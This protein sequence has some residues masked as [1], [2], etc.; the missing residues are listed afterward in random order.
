MFFPVEL[1][2][3]PFFNLLGTPSKEKSI[4]IYDSDPLCQC[5]LIKET[6]VWF[7]KYLGPVK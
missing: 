1:S 2:Q 7:D 3:N 6:L 4:K 5:R